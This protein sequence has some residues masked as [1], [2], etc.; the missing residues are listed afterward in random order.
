M[1]Q[2]AV[3][4]SGVMDPEKG[5]WRLQCSNKT[6][7]KFF[8]YFGLP[9]PNIKISCTHCGKYFEYRVSDFKK[10]QTAK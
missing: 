5:L 7:Q 4:I 6:C 8:D 2:A 10:Y 1:R 9:L 3:I